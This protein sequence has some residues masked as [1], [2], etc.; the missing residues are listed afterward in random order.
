[1]AKGVMV[2]IPAYNEAQTIGKVL[3]RLR[4]HGYTRVIVV[5]DGSSDQTSEVAGQEGAMLLRHVCN[6][7][8]GGAVV[9]GIKAA[10]QSQADIIVTMDAD[11]QHDP[12]EIP[13]LIAPIQ[14]G[15]ADIVIGSRMLDPRGMPWSRRLANHIA[16]LCTRL[17][18]RSSSSD[19]Q[20][21][22]RALSREAAGRLRLTT[23]GHE[24]C[25]EII[26]EIA[27]NRL[28]CKELPVRAIYT[29]YSLSKG[30]SFTV[31]LHTLHKLILARVRRRALPRKTRQERAS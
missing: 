18:F 28:R 14:N 31:G 26:A 17:L 25:S 11:G 20:S 29:D 24:V 19:S 4:E 30:Q 2:V 10:V 22:L 16:N 5:D 13:R 23:S 12:A 6:R 9:T 1:M 27:R 21:G 8:S 15:E 7:G 3:S